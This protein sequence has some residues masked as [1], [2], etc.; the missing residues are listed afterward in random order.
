MPSMICRNDQPIIDRG[1][2]PLMIVDPMDQQ[3]C[4]IVARVLLAHYPGHD[5]LVEADR[6]KGF[7]DIRNLSLDGAM[8]CRIKMGGL[9]SV[10]ELETLA[11]RYGGELLERY[12]VARGRMD[13]EA[14]DSLPT[15]F[16]GRLRAD[17]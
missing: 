4:E 2:D 8:G 10:S 3:I 12:H 6:R 14:V 11:M 13:R 7:I 1:F 5:W 16:A 15:D 17:V 9:A